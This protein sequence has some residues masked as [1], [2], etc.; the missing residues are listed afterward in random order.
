MAAVAAAAAAVLADAA[1]RWQTHHPPALNGTRAGGVGLTVHPPALN[2]PISVEDIMPETRPCQITL[3]VIRQQPVNPIS[4]P[5]Y[6]W[7]VLT[8]PLPVL[9]P[10]FVPPVWGFRPDPRLQ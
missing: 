5:I 6:P 10:L 9:P 8:G 2:A 4:L 7:P 1:G 3:C